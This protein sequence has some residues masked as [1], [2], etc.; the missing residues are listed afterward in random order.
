MQLEGIDFFETYAP[1]VQWTT[2]CLMIILEVLLGLKAKQGDV[3]C[4]FLHANLASDATV[5]VDMPLG[6][7]IKSKNG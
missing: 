6:I 1:V 5:Y 2:I 3:T 7:N 4:A